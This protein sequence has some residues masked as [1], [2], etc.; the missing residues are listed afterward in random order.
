M[1]AAMEQRSSSSQETASR[2]AAAQAAATAACAPALGHLQAALKGVAAEG[3]EPA[4]AALAAAM[5]TA[6][7]Q[8]S[9]MPAIEAD[10]PGCVGALGG[11]VHQLA[12]GYFHVADMLQ[13]RHKVRRMSTVA[14]A[15]LPHH[16]CLARALCS[17]WPLG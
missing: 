10:L 11:A 17:G 15:C 3:Q 13:E 1:A 5:R 16:T 4:A 8:L 7:E 2:L 6:V 12:A 9:G 14:F